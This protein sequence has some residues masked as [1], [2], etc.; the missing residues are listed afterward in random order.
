MT[1]ASP[2]RYEKYNAQSPA[3]MFAAGDF[4][5][6][7]K[8]IL[9]IDS[10]WIFCYTENAETI[11]PQKHKIG[12]TTMLKR[13]RTRSL[14]LLLAC[15]MLF[16]ILPVPIMAADGSGEAQEASARAIQTWDIEHKYSEDII[17][18]GIYYLRNVADQGNLDV[19]NA[20][21]ANG[22]GLSTYTHH[23]NPNQKFQIV[24]LGEGLYEIKPIYVNRVLHV[25]DDD[26][27]VIMD[28]NR[29][30]AQRFKLRMQ[31]S[32]TAVILSE[33]SN[34]TKAICY[35]AE[36]PRNVKQKDYASLSVKTQAQWEFIRAD[37]E[38]ADLYRVYYIKHADTGHYLDAV[39][40]DTANGTLLHTCH[41][42]GNTNEEWKLT[43]DYTGAYYLKAGHRRD[44]ALD[45]TDQ[46]AKIRYD[47]SSGTQGLSLIPVSVE[48]ESEPRYRIATTGNATVKYLM[49]GD[50][51]ADNVDYLHYV[52]FMAVAAEEADLWL[53][54]EVTVDM[55]TPERLALNEFYAETMDM[56]YHETEHYVYTPEKT[57][58][59]KVELES[60]V[61]LIWEIKARSDGSSPIIDS[62]V[63][64]ATRSVP[65]LRVSDV[66]LEAGEIYYI[67]IRYIRNP[68]I[69]TI[70]IKTRVRQWVFK[71]HSYDAPGKNTMAQEIDNVYDSVELDMG[72]KFYHRDHL[73][74]N[75]AYSSTDVISG[76]RDYNVEIFIYSGHGSENGLT[77][78]GVNSIYARDLPDMSNCELVIWNCCM[79]D[80]TNAS[81]ESLANQAIL[82]GAR[83]VIA[84]NGTICSTFTRRYVDLL[85]EEIETGKTIGDAS[86]AA[87]IRVQNDYEHSTSNCQCEYSD[88]TSA[89]FAS[90]LRIYG[91]LNHVIFPV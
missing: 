11:F 66:F 64:E 8:M 81:G 89:N 34:F 38:A 5:I 80:N 77:Y 74:A 39:N 65:E 51:M 31:T 85:F 13:K 12:E 55:K 2:K 58:R 61:S 10:L 56:A 30:G 90:C 3:A 14:C 63:R 29:S 73:T 6:L 37:S 57:S 32:S 48:G 28:K 45:Y 9:N 88:Y 20:G 21:S 79:S 17:D 41:F 68:E 67:A 19:D 50:S 40:G 87:L 49:Q 76:Y 1:A 22:T 59:Y 75:L 91:D 25:A 44:M 35:D 62:Y 33:S 60:N 71:G 15:V 70:N 18:G 23:G 47:G 46:R 82:K 72:I 83:T 36:H 69:G 27:L 78:N 7:E 54:E 52:D 24:Y 26:E 16:L 53:L 42:Y 4:H 86:A 43:Y 84:W